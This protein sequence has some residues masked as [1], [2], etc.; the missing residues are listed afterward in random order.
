M[1]DDSLGS[2]PRIYIHISL[3]KILG[4]RCVSEYLMHSCHT[5]GNWNGTFKYIISTVKHTNIHYN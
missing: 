2:L 5:T 3:S 4:A 1:S